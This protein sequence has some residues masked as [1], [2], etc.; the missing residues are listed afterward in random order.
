MRHSLAFSR[1]IWQSS[2][3]IMLNVPSLL[4]LSAAGL[5]AQCSAICDSGAAT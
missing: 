3:A 2:A 4:A 5:R 1:V